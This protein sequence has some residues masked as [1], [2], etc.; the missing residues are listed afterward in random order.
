MGSDSNRMVIA[1]VAAV[2]AGLVAGLLIGIGF[3][4]GI[5]VGVLVALLL[6][7]RRGNASATAA[8]APA[9][10]ASVRDLR[11]GDV[12]RHEGRDYVVEGTIR[13]DED[14]F[15]WA[16]HL[17]VDGEH[18]RWLSVEDD[19]GLEVVFWDRLK[20]PHLQ[21]GADRI[22]HEG[23]EY[24]LE[25]RGT[26]RFTA[27]GSTGTAPSGESEYADYEADGR[28]LSFERFGTAWEVA[29]GTPVS[30]HALDV[31]PG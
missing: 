21:P 7:A 29:V 24:V 27:E 11:L 6:V 25:E 23:V 16:E 22:P 13:F 8:E 26:A 10:A 3:G 18:K 12:V 20:A 30:E 2:V 17:L 9:R 1:V 4:I 5:A 19:E 15:T 28:L 14:G 31:Y